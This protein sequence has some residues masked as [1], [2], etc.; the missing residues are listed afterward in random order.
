MSGTSQYFHSLHC[1]LDDKDRRVS[2]TKT[3]FITFL[4]FLRE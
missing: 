2:R 4:G 1:R 3:S